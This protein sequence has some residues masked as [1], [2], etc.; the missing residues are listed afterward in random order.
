MRSH[1]A[2][3]LLNSA[4]RHVLGDDVRQRGSDVSDDK[5]SFDFSSVVSAY[6]LVFLL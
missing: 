5:L 1:T 2:T 6:S 3:H 4:L